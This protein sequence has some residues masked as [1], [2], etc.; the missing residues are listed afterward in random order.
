M[1]ANVDGL[2][3]CPAIKTPVHQSHL[4]SAEQP[5]FCRHFIDQRVKPLR[6]EQVIIGSFAVEGRLNQWSDVISVGHHGRQSKCSLFERFTLSVADAAHTDVGLMWE[7][8]LLRRPLRKQQVFKSW[9]LLF[10]SSFFGLRRGETV[11]NHGLGREAVRPKSFNAQPISRAFAL[12]TVLLVLLILFPSC[13]PTS[14]TVE[15]L[16]LKRQSTFQ[17]PPGRL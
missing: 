15:Y 10:S 4:E 2:T 9:R 13:I 17:L 14:W 3:P 1:A 11:V 16:A 7:M 8:L 5:V 12:R 6:E